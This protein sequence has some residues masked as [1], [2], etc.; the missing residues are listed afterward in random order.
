MILIAS[1]LAKFYATDVVNIIKW[2][3]AYAVLPMPTF[4]EHKGSMLRSLSRKC[5]PAL[6][7]KM[8]YTWLGVRANSM[9]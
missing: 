1:I 3:T 2:S 8:G 7:H 9:A 5:M 4:E 6:L